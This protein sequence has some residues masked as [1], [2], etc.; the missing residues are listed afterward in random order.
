MVVLPAKRPSISISTLYLESIPTA[1]LTPRKPANNE[2]CLNSGRVSRPHGHTGSGSDA[3]PP[4][5]APN[6][7][8]R[9][10]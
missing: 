2:A 9:A 8:N 3:P 6:A 10:K 7:P 1:E 5:A 4:H